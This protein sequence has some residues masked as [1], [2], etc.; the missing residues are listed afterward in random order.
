M[1][2]RKDDQSYI[3]ILY[4]LFIL[5]TSSYDVL[6]P[7]PTAPT[8]Y[9]SDALLTSRSVTI[10]V[11]FFSCT[12]AAYTDTSEHSPDK[13]AENFS[14]CHIFESAAS[15][16]SAPKPAPSETVDDSQFTT[17]SRSIKS[18]SGSL[19]SRLKEPK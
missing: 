15:V 2:K 16:K 4:I 12:S 1:P 3:Y 17:I 11:F 13:L 19:A 9:T 5:G 6:D 7:K 14:G 18:I 10:S 8:F